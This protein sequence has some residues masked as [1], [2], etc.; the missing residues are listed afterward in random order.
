MKMTFSAVSQRRM[1]ERD[2]LL[3]SGEATMDDIETKEAYIHLRKCDGWRCP[4]F[5]FR[6]LI[7]PNTE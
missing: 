2:S 3:A 6:D 1:K 7:S 5:R 4:A